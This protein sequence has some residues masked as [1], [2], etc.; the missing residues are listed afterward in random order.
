MQ[1]VFDQWIQ[2]LA[3]LPAPA[4]W[5][6][7]CGFSVALCF[8]TIILMI[9]ILRLSRRQKAN[10]ALLIE[11]KNDI[12]RLRR[13]EERRSLVDLNTN[14]FFL[15][16]MSLELVDSGPLATSGSPGLENQKISPIR[17]KLPVIG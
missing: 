5:I 1:L 14:K 10:A 13:A 12:D 15:N 9:A 16:E 3:T 8:L 11:M 6:A 4:P 17:L 2:M 7:L